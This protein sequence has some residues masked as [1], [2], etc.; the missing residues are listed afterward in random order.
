MLD[1]ELRDAGARLLA[2]LELREPLV[3]LVRNLAEL[4][5]LLVVSR[6][7]EATVRE[8]RRR[9]LDYRAVNQRNDVRLRRK[10]RT[11]ARRR[12]I[13]PRHGTKNVDNLR[14]R[15][16][17]IRKRPEVARIRPHRVDLLHEPLEVAHSGEQPSQRGKCAAVVDER[18]HAVQ[19]RVDVGGARERTHRPVPERARAHGGPGDVEDS[20][21]RRRLRNVPAGNELQVPQRSRV[22]DERVVRLSYRE[23]PDVRY[24]MAQR[25][26]DVVEKRASGGHEVA[27]SLESEAVQR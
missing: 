7:D 3:P 21:E 17:R 10:R 6:R 13:L 23:L 27:L 12:G 14:Y 16:Q 26:A 20:E 2:R 4:V 15:P 8:K 18:L 9:L 5:Q 22:Q 25:R 1:L 24:G 11:T 19:P